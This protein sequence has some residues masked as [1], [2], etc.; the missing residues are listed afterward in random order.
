M[1]EF[2]KYRKNPTVIGS[3][4]VLSTQDFG[5]TIG[6][7]GVGNMILIRYDGVRTSMACPTFAARFTA[8]EQTQ[9]LQGTDW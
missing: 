2:R 9:Q 8:T 1:A 3:Y 4:E 6:T 5:G 7:K